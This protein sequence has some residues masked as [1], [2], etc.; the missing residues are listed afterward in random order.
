[1]PRDP[2]GP[3]PADGGGLGEFGEGGVVDGF[4]ALLDGVPPPI[5]SFFVGAGDAVDGLAQDDAAGHA[6]DDVA[7]GALPSAW[8][9]ISRQASA[10]G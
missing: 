5:G 7:I 4:G 2:A 3:E 8:R 1:M 10:R 6:L 9:K